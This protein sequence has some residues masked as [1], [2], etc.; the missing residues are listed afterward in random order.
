MKYLLIG[1]VVALLSILV[2]FIMDDWT[3]V[4]QIAGAVG[5]ICLVWGAL[6]SGAFVGGKQNTRNMASENRREREEKFIRMKRAVMVAIPNIVVAVIA[7]IVV[8]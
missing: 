5:I 4:Y 8:A 2:G 3:L 6:V 1:G 7:F